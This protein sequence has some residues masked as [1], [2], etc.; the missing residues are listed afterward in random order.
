MQTK[1]RA[2][3]VKFGEKEK[4]KK[5]TAKP[6][7][8]VEKKADIAPPKKKSEESTKKT[9][10]I[11]AP[12]P[13]KVEA[14]DITETITEPKDLEEKLDSEDSGLENIKNSNDEKPPVD[15]KKDAEEQISTEQDPDS[16]NENDGEFF[17]TP[18]D[19]YKKKKSMLA[20]FF[21]V[22]FVTFLLGLILFAGI[23]YV[24]LNKGQ[25]S[26]FAPK[27]EALPTQA[28]VK[29]IPTPKP[30]DLTVY[31]INVLNGTSTG[32]LAGKLKT[33]LTSAG[34]KVGTT[35]NAEKDTFDKTEIV[36]S[37]RVDKAY[38]E[39]LREILKKSYLISPTVTAASGTADVVI[40][41]G[42][43]SAK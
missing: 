28:A 21:I 13:S 3:T 15:L 42:S 26:I 12:S 27:H 16:I 35:G 5:E 14:I 34:F 43:A 11:E 4:P 1:K 32:G 41:I 36:A 38:L 29:E 2:K 24:F 23:Y 9:K 19:G 6:T 33:D 30:I 37:K 39:K 40:T 10:E 20:Y 18:P 31:T 22:A 25:N 17:N 7:S 8:V